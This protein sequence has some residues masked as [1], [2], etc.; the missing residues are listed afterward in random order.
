MRRTILMVAIMA[1]TVLVA[2][3]DN[4]VNGRTDELGEPC[5]IDPVKGLTY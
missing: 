1:L 5:W 2:N 4:N 3:K